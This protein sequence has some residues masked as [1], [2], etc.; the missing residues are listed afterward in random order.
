[1]ANLATVPQNESRFTQNMPLHHG[2]ELGSVGQAFA[3]SILVPVAYF[4]FA[5]QH[6][7]HG[8]GQRLIHL[9]NLFNLFNILFLAGPPVRKVVKQSTNL[10]K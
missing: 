2:T 3:L 8:C 6:I 9:F 5:I 7:Q 1:M 10:L 4:L